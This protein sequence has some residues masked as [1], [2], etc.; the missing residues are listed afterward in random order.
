MPDLEIHVKDEIKVVD[1]VAQAE[2][3]IIEKIRAH[4]S[5]PFEQQTPFTI[6]IENKATRGPPDL[7]I[8][9]SDTIKTKDVP[10]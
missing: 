9:V 10:R 6:R 4:F 3:Y 5:L 2:K 1:S 8:H 7:G